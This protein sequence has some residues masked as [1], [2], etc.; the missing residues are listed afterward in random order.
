MIQIY[1]FTNIV[2]NGL[3]LDGIRVSKL[4]RLGKK[5][6]NKT[7]PLLVTLD[8][9]N[10]KKSILSK[11]SSHR[12]SEHWKDVYISLDLTAKERE[13]IRLLHMELKRRKSAGKKKLIIKRGKIVV[14]GGNPPT[15]QHQSDQLTNS[16]S[17]S[18]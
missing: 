16:E 13:A 7:Q 10:L 12:K 9:F 14:T 11:S 1:S 3:G 4:F 6:D 8:L 17:T 2:T 5:Q 18:N 15:D